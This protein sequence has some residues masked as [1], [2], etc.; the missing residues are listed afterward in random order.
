MDNHTK[1]ANMTLLFY[2][3]NTAYE[4]KW[5]ALRQ[6][7]QFMA[8]RLKAAHLTAKDGVPIDIYKKVTGIPEELQ[9][10]IGE[11]PTAIE[12]LYILKSNENE[13]SKAAVTYGN[14]STDTER[15]EMAAARKND[16]GTKAYESLKQEK[17]QRYEKARAI[18]ARYFAQ[19]ENK[20][21]VQVYNAIRVDND[22]AFPRMDAA[23]IAEWNM[24][25]LQQNNYLALI[26]LAMNGNENEYDVW[27][28]LQASTGKPQYV[29][30]GRSISRIEISPEHQQ[31]VMLDMYAAWVKSSEQVEHF[32]AYSGYVRKL[33]AVYGSNSN[34]ASGLREILENRY[35]KGATEY[36]NGFIAEKANPYAQA[37]RTW[38]DKVMR[39]FRGKTVT[40]YLA[41]KFSGVVMQGITSS[42]PFGGYLAPHEYLGGLL[43][44]AMH[45]RHMFEHINDLSVHMDNRSADPM[46]KL[47]DE[48]YQATLNKPG[49]ALASV[50][51]A[52]M[53]GLTLVD[54]FAVYP[55]WLTLYEKETNRLRKESPDMTDSQYQA[56]LYADEITRAVQPGSRDTDI[57]PLHKQKGSEH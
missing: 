40:A 3:E 10:F 12:M 47:V 7:R 53:I 41:L 34:R 39:A 19:E 48:Q 38:I 45:P 30:K 1:G 52:G 32:I 43:K 50:N 22:S 33:N 16:N 17:E 25:V 5:R 55:G 37:Q 51:R 35:G 6:R 4:T 15:I 29:N 57:A 23:S 54:R 9:P 44:F 49:H 11:T 20:N 14:F 46:Y 2:M 28:D 27:K 8:D 36:I 24:P 42:A 56:V 26:R 18:A 13:Y 21:I 31:P